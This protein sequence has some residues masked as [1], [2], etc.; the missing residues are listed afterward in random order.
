[1]GKGKSY[2]IVRCPDC[3]QI[4]TSA[5]LSSVS[6][7]ISVHLR[8]PCVLCRDL[9]YV[10]VAQRHLNVVRPG[11][12]GGWVLEDSLVGQLGDLAPEETEELLGNL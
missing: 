11:A 2:V 1:M 8:G 9:G 10:R 3:S 12:D 5:P 4:E 7:N 6:G